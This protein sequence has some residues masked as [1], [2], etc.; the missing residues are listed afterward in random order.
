MNGKNIISHCQ[1]GNY[2]KII[3]TAR[4]FCVKF[5]LVANKPSIWMVKA[6]A[7]SD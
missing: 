1:L 5:F 6:G 2:Q 3:Q 4:L 7:T